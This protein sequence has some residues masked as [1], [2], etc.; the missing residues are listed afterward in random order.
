MFA[1]RTWEVHGGCLT[2]FDGNLDGCGLSL[3]MMFD[4]VILRLIRCDNVVPVDSQNL[5]PTVPRL[6]LQ[7]CVSII[8]D[9]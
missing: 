8:I 1:A 4:V 3:Y 6:Y 2:A 7:R 9:Y 5:C